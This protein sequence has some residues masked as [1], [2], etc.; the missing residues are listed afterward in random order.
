M[1]KLASPTPATCSI[2][3]T[4]CLICGSPVIGWTY[5]ATTC[6]GNLR[7]VRYYSLEEHV[8]LIPELLS[9]ISLMT[10]DHAVL[11]QK[12]NFSAEKLCENVIT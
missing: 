6:T 11:L 9:F 10:C 3:S 12:C 1:R 5:G 4:L 2:N 7:F 8:I